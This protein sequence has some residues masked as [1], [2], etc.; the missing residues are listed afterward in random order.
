MKL[1]AEL[2]QRYK[3]D[4]PS[5]VSYGFRKEEKSYVYLKTVHDG[6]FKLILEYSAE[7]LSGKLLDSVFE[8]EYCLIDNDVSFGFIASLKEEC[9]KVLLDVRDKCFK[10]KVYLFDQSNRIDS[11][12]GKTYGTFPEFL[13]KDTPGF[14]VYRNEVSRKWYALIMDLSRKKIVP[15]GENKV[16]EVM[17]LHIGNGTEENLKR[18]GIYPCYHMNKKYWVSIILDE[19]L[20]DDDIFPLIEQSYQL[21]KKK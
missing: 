8:D 2:F 18:K 1:I 5:L 19:T 10:K 21:S 4:I 9:E 6:Q 11:W 16:V 13:W 17:N 3:G 7:K 20:R 12:I 15:D 14:G